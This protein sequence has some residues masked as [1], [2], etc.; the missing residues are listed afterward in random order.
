MDSLAGDNDTVI[1]GTLP[2]RMVSCLHTID[3]FM[4]QP[5]PVLSSMVVAEKRKAEASGAS[6]V[7][8]VANI[9]GLKD[10]KNIPDQA[11]LA[12][13]GMDSLMG[14]EIK[15]TLERNYDVVM[16]AAEIRQ[17]S[18]GKLKALG[19]EKRL[20]LLQMILIFRFEIR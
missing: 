6:L 15:Q 19:N 3:L 14:A 2:Q 17:L 18:F 10:L 4:Q 7:S 13:L 5:H 12:D 9:L 11:S 20:K 16:S 8:C 1:G